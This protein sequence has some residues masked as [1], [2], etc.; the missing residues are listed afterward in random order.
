M[1]V[2]PGVDDPPAVTDRPR[3]DIFIHAPRASSDALDAFLFP[4]GY[5]LYESGKLID[6]E[7]FSWHTTPGSAGGG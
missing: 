4:P 3:K 2:A 1:K 5:N 6:R 7:T